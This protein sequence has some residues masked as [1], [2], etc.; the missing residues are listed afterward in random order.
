VTLE[1]SLKNKRSEKGNQ[2][3]LKVPKMFGI[4]LKANKYLLYIF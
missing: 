2:N 1:V 3:E 4:S